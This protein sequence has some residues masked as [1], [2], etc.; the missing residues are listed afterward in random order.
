MVTDK[1]EP[2]SGKK[3]GHVI[4]NQDSDAVAD[5]LK[6][7]RSEMN[8]LIGQFVEEQEK[9]RH[10]GT[11]P[12]AKRNR[13]RIRQ[14]LV[15]LFPLE[16]KV[17]ERLEKKANYL[18]PMDPGSLVALEDVRKL[19]CYSTIAAHHLIQIPLW[20]EASRRKGTVGIQKYRI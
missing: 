7:N 17:A 15:K 20:V 3:W 14:S 9:A 11:P 5:F 18:T 10:V 4:L 2:A 1:F 12:A 16:S 6:E 19:C 13:S 8:P